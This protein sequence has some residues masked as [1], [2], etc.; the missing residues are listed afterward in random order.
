MIKQYQVP[1]VFCFELLI[2]R[3]KPQGFCSTSPE[4]KSAGLWT[5]SPGLF[6][7]WV[8][9]EECLNILARSLAESLFRLLFYLVT[10]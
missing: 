7:T 6:R 2:L 4:S 1:G 10:M 5:E 3:L 8:K 9:I